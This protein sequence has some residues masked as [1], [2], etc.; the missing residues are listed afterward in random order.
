M[1]GS[2]F[3]E[4]ALGL[5][6][7]FLL[8]SLMCS[9]ICEVIARVRRSRS[10][11]LFE[12]IDGLVKSDPL[13]KSDKLGD[14]ID[15]HPLVQALG[16]IDSKGMRR[17]PSYL[18]STLFAKVVIALLAKS[19]RVVASAG[20]A[21]APGTEQDAVGASD[22]VRVEA[23]PLA[24]LRV[25]LDA[26][27]PEATLEETPREDR[28]KAIAAWFDA[29]MERLS[30]RY[31]RST[32]LTVFLLAVPLTLGL[33]VDT[34][35]VANQLQQDKTLRDTV[36]TSATTFANEH[37]DLGAL[38]PTGQKLN[39]QATPI[40][41]GDANGRLL[42]LEVQI[43]RLDFP[44]GW[45][46][47]EDV[48]AAV[49]RAIEAK[50]AVAVAKADLEVPEKLWRLAQRD[51]IAALNS[52]VQSQSKPADRKPLQ[53]AYDEAKQVE[54]AAKSVYVTAQQTLAAASLESEHFTLRATKTRA[55]AVKL[56]NPLEWDWTIAL[57]HRFLL[58]ITGWLLTMIAV[59]LG[60]RF[61][62]DT[63]N[64]VVSI[65]TGVK[66]ADPKPAASAT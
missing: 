29:A 58:R 20:P 2:T 30:G 8:M 17:R 16:T 27:T 38:D 61:W 15:N 26:L 57:V 46:S 65:R 12:A 51:L 43:E 52:L 63:L 53:T 4:T 62:F 19:D 23:K 25:A 42:G 9:V 59:S 56:S 33:N 36:V 3:I 48:Q 11:F 64:K 21:S 47:K 40:Q 28:I 22:W 31:K 41:A 24:E 50:Q 60:T 55:R 66:P 45:P 37:K 13:V 32:Q 5:S 35:V 7:M 54:S 34:L 10:R 14:L 6:L 39:E 44:I 1:F 18:P 49:T